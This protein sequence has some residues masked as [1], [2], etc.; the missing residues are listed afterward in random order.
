[1]EVSPYVGA[2]PLCRHGYLRV[3]AD[4]RYLTHAE[5]TPFLWI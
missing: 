3:A 2:N 4:H 1:V 5:S